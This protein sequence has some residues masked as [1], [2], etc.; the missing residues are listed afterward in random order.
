MLQK[1]AGPETEPA[2]ANVKSNQ[3]ARFDIG[4]LFF[5]R[6]QQ[7]LD[8]VLSF[9]NEDIRPD[10]VILDQGSA[11]DQRKF[12]QTALADRPNVRFITLDRNI[13]V[14]AGRNRLCRE[15]RSDWILFVDNDITL[16]TRGGL[17]QINSAVE[18]STDFDAF[19]LRVLNVHE[20]LFLE[21]HRIT[22]EPGRWVTETVGTNVETT[23][24][25]PG[26]AVV[27]RRS[28]LLAHP[29]DESYFVGFED[30]ELALRAVAAGRPLRIKNFDDVTLA[31]KHIPNVND[32]DIASTRVRY[33]TP[34][35]TRSFETLK[36]AYSGDVFHGW[37]EWIAIQ[38][39]EMIASHRISPR[40]VDNNAN[41]VM[42][43]DE[44]DSVSDGILRRL[45]GGMGDR[46]ILTSV[47]AQYLEE[48]ERVLKR[49]L[50]SDPH[51][52]HFMDRADFL[53][54][55]TAATIKNCA[56]LTGWRPLEIVHRLCQSHLTF[57]ADDTLFL[58]NEDIELFRPFYWLSDGYCVLSPGLIDICKQN[59]D[60]PM[61]LALISGA[62]DDR[63]ACAGSWRRFFQDVARQARPDAPN[64]KSLMIEKFYL[65]ERKAATLRGADRSMAIA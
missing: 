51:F 26:G 48:P 46:F 50:D 42:V 8:T 16:N 10:I 5:N 17:A 13:G 36:A 29:Y 41:A 35:I 28:L 11:A 27:I 61:P 57:S 12:L 1:T 49:I 62:E 38:K 39:R 31:H 9:C 55:V 33:S 56:A 32:A 3:R 53:K 19:S 65:L 20:N 22:G 52:I 45:D 25:F 44:P 59:S 15:C 6:S 2:T 63:E 37:E 7:T 47:Y 23:N 18:Q 14:S 58:S 43:A 4:V 64:W 60:C 30:Q 34:L 40:I 54:I 24:V 21:R